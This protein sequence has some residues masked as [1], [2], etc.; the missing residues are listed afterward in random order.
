MLTIYTRKQSSFITFVYSYTAS[1]PM[2]YTYALFV[3]RPP[4]SGSASNTAQKLDWKPTKIRTLFHGELKRIVLGDQPVL[5]PKK[6]AK[7][8]PASKFPATQIVPPLFA[9]DRRRHFNENGFF[10]GKKNAFRV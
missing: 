9:T 3:N 8:V 5:A 4:P 7:T 1:S 2:E 6:S 10:L